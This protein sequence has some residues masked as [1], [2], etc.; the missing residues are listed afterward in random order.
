MSFWRP[1]DF[2]VL[3]SV[4]SLIPRNLPAS[5]N[6]LSKCVLN[7]WRNSW[8]IFSSY[9]SLYILVHSSPAF[10]TE[11]IAL[12][13]P[14][15]LVFQSL[16][17]HQSG[18]MKHFSLLQP[19]GSGVCLCGYRREREREKERERDMYNNTCLWVHAS[20][21]L[22]ELWVLT[23]HALSWFYHYPLI[24]IFWSISRIMHILLRLSL[25]TQFTVT[26][27]Q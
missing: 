20:M 5:W 27:I 12:L 15:S 23:K 2:S 9:S 1:R 19:T 18:S 4:L 7:E 3:F 21:C 17:G 24:P 13:S 6:M 11:C 8:Q 14:L 26:H 16:S 10:S 22:G 25:N